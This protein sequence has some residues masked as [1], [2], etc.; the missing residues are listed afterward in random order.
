MNYDGYHG[1]DC[2][3]T[4]CYQPPPRRLSDKEILEKAQRVLHAKAKARTAEKHQQ[5][6]NELETELAAIDKA[7]GL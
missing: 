3:D 6:R 7:L 2:D 5:L 4:C 1:F